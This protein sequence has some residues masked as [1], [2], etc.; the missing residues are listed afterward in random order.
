MSPVMPAEF[1]V[2]GQIAYD[3]T[4]PLRWFWSHVRR[5]FHFTAWVLVG[6]VLFVWLRT[7]IPVLVGDA[8]EIV[9][10]PE[11]GG[12]LLKVGLTIVGAALLQMV[13]NLTSAWSNEVVAQRVERDAREE[14][15]VALLSK[16]QTFHDLQRVG[17]VMSRAT[18]DV[19]QLNLMVSPAV[20]LIYQSMLSLAIPIV[21]AGFI[22]W[23]LVL[24]PGLFTVVFFWS[25]RGY[26][27]DLAPLTGRLRGQM[28]QVSA[29]LNEVLTNIKVVRNFTQ[30][31]RE[32]ERFAQACRQYKDLAVLQGH[33]QA[34]YLPLLFVGL[35]LGAGM[36]HALILMRRGEITPGQV[37]SYVGLLGVLRFP[38]FI[39]I[40]SF[41]L[42]QSGLASAARILEM[43]Q[44]R[45]DIDQN[46]EGPSPDIVGD[47]VFD[48]VSFR[49]GDSGPW[50]LED[51]NFTIPAGSRV[52]I[53]G[54][55]GSGKTTLVKLLQRLYD[56]SA[57]AITVD[58]INLKDWNLQ[59]LRSQMGVIEQDIFLFSDSL[60][61]NIS[62]GRADATRQEVEQ[63]AQA[64]QAHTF[65]SELPQGYDTVVGARGLTLS[66]GQKQRVAI[67]R[68]LLSNPRILALDDAT[69]AIDSATEDQIQKAL[70]AVL[71]GRTSLII[72]HRLAQIRRADLILVLKRGKV[73]AQ[74]S[75]ERLIHTSPEYRDVFAIYGAELPPLEQRTGEG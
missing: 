75:H 10:H 21:M 33:V 2:K 72:T 29:Q 16:S 41:A 12:S 1:S 67:A 71:T 22:H 19:K 31:L 55:T 70:V 26:M 47:I 18:G 62:F 30:E 39:S 14:L 32:S 74:G 34:R 46:M 60:A 8:F 59:A 27:R 69:S 56:V 6:T 23:Q 28:G 65:I 66:G 7:L 50:V 54:P 49:Y 11:L 3:R 64:A 48:H 35:T 43:I 61:Q 37:V 15:F 44:A 53:V 68:A 57:G 45:V 4:S 40:F 58:G 73:V 38:T 13:I 24:I 42:V 5:H 36:F 9:N 63:A 20:N 52:A 51:L 25:L 17:D